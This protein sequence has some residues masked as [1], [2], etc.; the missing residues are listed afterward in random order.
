MS[1]IDPSISL[2]ML[3]CTAI[4]FPAVDLIIG[5]I[6]RFNASQL[7]SGLTATS[8]AARRSCSGHG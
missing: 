3:A 2:S 6:I 5:G 7:V 4:E 8:L 1:G